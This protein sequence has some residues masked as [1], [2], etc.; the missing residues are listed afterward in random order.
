MKIRH[1]LAWGTCVSYDF[2]E[3]EIRLALWHTHTHAHASETKWNEMKIIIII[4][5]CVVTVCLVLAHPHCRARNRVRMEL[6]LRCAWSLCT[7]VSC[8]RPHLIRCF[9][10]KLL[11]NI[12]HF[13]SHSC[14]RQPLSPHAVCWFNIRHFC[15]TGKA[16]NRTR[17]RSV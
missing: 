10:H 6:W 5:L 7:T 12:L 8:W 11:K 2:V 17:K 3:P 16:K 15:C 13:P 1:S 14:R 9:A 4:V